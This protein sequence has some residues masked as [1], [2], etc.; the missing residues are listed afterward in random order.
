MRRMIPAMAMVLLLT[1]AAGA[2]QSTTNDKVMKSLPGDAFT[3]TDYYKQNV[4]DPSDKKIGDIKDVLIDKTGQI[5]ALMISV[6]G[7]LGA[8]EK[9]VAVPFNAVKSTTKNNKTYLTMNASK[10]ELKNAVGFNYD[11]STTKWVAENK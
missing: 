9:D 3:V 11:S 1:G 2:Q 10:D 8:G 6:G 5:K 7:F 4:Y